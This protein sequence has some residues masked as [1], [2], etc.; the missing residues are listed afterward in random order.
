MSWTS[1][2]AVL[3]ARAHLCTSKKSSALP[4]PDSTS[5]GCRQ[6]LFLKAEQVPQLLLV[7]HSWSLRPAGDQLGGPLLDSLWFIKAF[8]TL[9]S[10]NLDTLFQML[11]RMPATGEEPLSTTCWLR[12]CQHTPACTC[13]ALLQGHAADS[14]STW[15]QPEAHCLFLQS[16]FLASYSPAVW[17]Y[18][19]LT[20]GFCICLSL[21]FMRTLS[22]CL[23]ILTRSHWIAAL[24]S[25][26][27]TAPPMLL[28]AQQICLLN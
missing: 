16:C 28:R 4:S 8:L 1:A 5:G 26:T 27:L 22:A 2:P 23:L 9:D 21:N 19:I 24:P 6:L 14:C 13:L 18:S 12:C 10:A 11:S 20:T 15:P 17:V 7:H 3:L 25:S